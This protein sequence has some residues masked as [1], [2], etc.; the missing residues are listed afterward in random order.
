MFSV[1]SSSIELAVIIRNTFY[2]MN[3]SLD[4]S[5][6]RK[7]RKLNDYNMLLLKK[8][9]KLK[10]IKLHI[11]WIV[12]KE[13]TSHNLV[14]SSNSINSMVKDLENFNKRGLAFKETEKL[15]KIAKELKSIDIENSVEN[16]WND[17]I[18]ESDAILHPIEI[19]HGE[20]VMSSYFKGEKPFPIVKSRNDIPDAFIYQALLTI[21]KDNNPLIFIVEDNNLRN[22]LD[23]IDGITA[24]KSFEDLFNLMEFKLIKQQFDKVE[25]YAEELI[26]LGEN[27]KLIKDLVIDDIHRKG[28]LNGLTVYSEYIPDDL[29]EGLVEE[30]W[31]ITT[32]NVQKDKIEF[33]DDYFYIPIEGNGIFTLEYFIF[34]SDFYRY[35]GRK[36]NII[37]AEWN[38]HYF[39]VSENYEFDFSYKYKFKKESIHNF[40]DA[41]IENIV[42]ANLKVSDNY[43]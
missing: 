3:I 9:S 20:L 4:S 19:N 26:Y 25:H 7:D 40:K 5:I 8:L 42:I 37:D 43:R 34:K 29:N 17:F 35:E 27:L 16:H 38:K 10:L 32:L 36:I 28:I 6:L 23:N 14:D 39:A 21:S 31:Q 30:V 2:E 12:Y 18:S 22:S 24:L 1:F 13:I 41:E 33:L 15:K 11:P